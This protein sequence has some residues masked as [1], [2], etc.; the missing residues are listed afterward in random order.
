MSGRVTIDGVSAHIQQMLD[1]QGV[2]TPEEREVQLSYL[3]GN[4][5]RYTATL[6][7]LGSVCQRPF[8]GLSV[9]DIG[10]YPGHLAALLAREGAIVQAVTLVT[11]PAFEA[12][13]RQ[14]S[15]QIVVCDVER[16]RLPIADGSAAVVLCCE[17][18]EHLDGDVQH[19]LGEA[20][21]MVADTGVLVLT[22]PNHAALARRWDLL[23]GRSVYP[24][25]DDP[26]Y[27]FYA[28]VGRRNPWRHV[29]EFTAAEIH[30]LLRQAG[31]GR[32][33]VTTESPPLLLQDGLSARGYLSSTIIQAASC[34]I[35]AGGTLIVATARRS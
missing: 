10:A 26:V 2:L 6:R 30:G 14:H 1:S 23:R 7:H 20:Y 35:P 29:R 28:G 32:V 8:I 16:D 33:E 5:W 21:R 25:L 13:M 11:S 22:T 9:L 17:L 24:R 12:L 15:V 27:P 18:I 19:A 3:S 34:L 31:F 4:A